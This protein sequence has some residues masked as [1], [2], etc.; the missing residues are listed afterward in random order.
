MDS[1]DC[2]MQTTDTFSFKEVC[3]ARAVYQVSLDD[4]RQGLDEADYD[5]QELQSCL[6]LANF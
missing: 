3:E 2:S 4:N 6:V 5:L 1:A